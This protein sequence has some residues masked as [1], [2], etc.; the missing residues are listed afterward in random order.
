MGFGFLNQFQGRQQQP[1]PVNLGPQPQV[2]P[3]NLGPGPGVGPMNLGPQPMKQLG[4]N[5][6]MDNRPQMGNS[7]GNRFQQMSRRGGTQGR[8]F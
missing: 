7:L 4:S 1:G 3:V 6:G 5:A 2:G 8:R